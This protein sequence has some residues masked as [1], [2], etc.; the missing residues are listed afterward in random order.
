[1]Q[2]PWPEQLGSGQTIS[3][4]HSVPTQPMS[5]AHEPSA[6]AQDPWPLQQLT[7]EQSGPVKP[8]MQR[9]A[10]W[11]QSPLPEHEL[12][13]NELQSR[14]KKLSSHVHCLLKASHSPCPEQFPGQ[15]PLGLARIVETSRDA[16]PFVTGSLLGSLKVKTAE[17]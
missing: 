2:V 15:L 17:E 4:E 14:P 7:T 11:T 5:H 1:M 6:V 12:G 3:T 16:G 9:Q 8:A 10:P 13:Q